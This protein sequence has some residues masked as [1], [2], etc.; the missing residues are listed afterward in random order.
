ML[1][2]TLAG[3]RAYKVRLLLSSVS[4]VLG[5][6]FIAGTFMMTDSINQ[7]FDHSY[8]RA[9]ENV[10]A[11]VQPSDTAKQRLAAQPGVT[12]LTP[13]VLN[14]VRRVNGVAAVAGRIKA[15][16]PMRDVDGRLMTTDGL[17]GSALAIPDDVALSSGTVVAGTPPRRP[18][19][20]VVDKDTVS[21]RHLTI[22]QQ[23]QIVAHDQQVRQFRLVGAMEFGVDNRA[24]G[25]TVVGLRPDVALSV[26]GHTGYDQIDV[27][28]AA[29]I[30][31]AQLADRLRAAL[32]SSADLAVLTGQQFTQATL[33]HRAKI[34]GNLP[35]ILAVFSVTALLVAAFVIYN[36]FTI[37]VTQRMRQLAL[38]RCVGATRNQV[39]VS[40]LLE[41]AVVGLLAS[42]AGLF[43]G[44]GIAAGLRSVVRA[45]STGPVPAGGVVVHSTT[46]VAALTAGMVVTVAAAAIPARAATAVAPISA[47]R[48]QPDTTASPAR[49]AVLRL[50][51]AIVLG[52]T[53]ITVIEFGTRSSELYTGIKVI[54]VGCATVFLAVLAI[55][56]VVV[57]PLTRVLG[58]LPAKVLG[59]P[60]RL[61]AANA[62]RN[63]GRTATTMAALSVG[64]ML[65]SLFTVI[66]DSAMVTQSQWIE[67]HNPYDYSVDPLAGSDQTVPFSVAAELR[68][69]PELAHVAALDGTKTNVNGHPSD[70]GAVES[71]AYGSLFQPNVREGSLTDF[72]AGTVAVSNELAATL[73][74]KVGDTVSVATPRSGTVTARLT[75]IYQV[76]TGHG[77]DWFDVLLPREDFLRGFA[78]AGDTQVRILA[79]AGVNIAD[80]RAAVQGVIAALHLLHIGSLAEKKSDLSGSAQ[81]TLTLF[82]VM[83]A[84]AI[85]IAV[86]GIA[87]T[88]SLSAVERSRESALL[89]AL[90]LSRGAMMEML[91]VEAVLTALLGTL[92]GLTLGVSFGWAFEQLIGHS[93]GGAVLSVPVAK[94]LAYAAIATA[95]SL[96]AALLPGSRAA[97]A[98]VVTALAD[99]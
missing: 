90:G 66:Q 2:V 20:A 16:A 87:N 84:M 77:I 96:C 54:G 12:V 57:G 51:V 52:I 48:Q 23:I 60:A 98:S 76:Y 22:G 72:T 15:P 32:G 28:A 97:R 13:E 89:R 92:I 11:A 99:A 68:K 5:V 64:V 4:I 17:V 61:A 30:S 63:P 73:R 80:S 42:V 59:T 75:L 3:L 95:A 47:V 83:L 78:P 31:Q 37:L 18:D 94:L 43:A 24:N 85:V 7:V 58:W 35:Q 74:L 36:T 45:L 65:M 56:P 29:G 1:R 8:A 10:D 79:G 46:V 49:I 69:K 70:V 21:E 88:L 93:Q 44:I 25:F 19:E 53:G 86:L 71:S 81:S 55:G 40:T 91:W 82:T 62:R 6:A 38:L 50:W 34:A 41:A 39:F 33:L 27:R 26:T 14:A 67:A 9:A